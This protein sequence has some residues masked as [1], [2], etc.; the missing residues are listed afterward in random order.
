MSIDAYRN[1][2]SHLVGAMAR[3]NRE[4]ALAGEITA[5]S[6][7]QQ[8]KLFVDGN[9]DKRLDKLLGQLEFVAPAFDDFEELVAEYVCHEP[10]AAYDTGTT[11][12]DRLLRWL[13]EHRSLTPEQ[14][15]YVACQRARN[16]L[17]TLARK[18]R[19]LH[20]A[21]QRMRRFSSEGVNRSELSDQ[22][23][24]H[25]NPIRVWTRLKT[26][27]LLGD[28]VPPADVLFFARDGQSTSA[29]FEPAGRD[30]LAE[31]VNLAPCPLSSWAAVSQIADRNE[32]E[33]FLHDLVQ[34]G[35]AAYSSSPT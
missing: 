22:L 17:E 25:V 31:L 12:A 10:P 14:G 3:A 8:V 7:L 4:K 34:M 29:A 9:F 24:I 16:A 35:L 11:D 15:D 32:F 6:T 2:L 13:A 23:L 26:A 18:S 30:L 33:P 27:A 1:Q 28:D 21:F 5:D 19:A 20:V